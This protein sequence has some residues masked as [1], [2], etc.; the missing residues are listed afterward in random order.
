MRKVEW[1][2]WCTESK[3]KEDTWCCSKCRG[4]NILTRFFHNPYSPFS[5]YAPPISSFK[6]LVCHYIPLNIPIS[7]NMPPYLSHEQLQAVGSPLQEVIFIIQINQSTLLKNQKISSPQASS[8]FP[9]KH[10]V[11][12]FGSCTWGATVYKCCWW[13]QF[14]QRGGQ[15]WEL[16]ARFYSILITSSLSNANGFQLA[17]FDSH[18]WSYSIRYSEGKRSKKD[19]YT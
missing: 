6:S 13:M 10:F 16:Q 8:W 19:C 15:R 3:Y 5:F 2:T 7:Q 1:W 9:S 12:S 17:P 14:R 4:C 11:T 18:G